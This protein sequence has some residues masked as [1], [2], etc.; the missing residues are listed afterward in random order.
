MNIVVCVKQV[1]DTETKIRIDGSGAWIDESAVNFVV[2]PFDEFAVEEALRI[3]EA[4]GGDVVV[5]SAGPERVSAALRSCLALGADRA[6]ALADA[7]LERSD[8]LG[9]AK[10]L[11]ALVRTLP[12]DLVLF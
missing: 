8:S 1:P 11:A 2:S 9:I 3:K 7:S 12:H 4:K 5:V 6:V 10:A